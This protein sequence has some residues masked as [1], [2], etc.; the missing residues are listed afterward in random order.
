MPILFGINSSF[1]PNNNIP[2]YT[3]MENTKPTNAG[4]V[5]N[6]FLK[7]MNNEDFNAARK[8]AR[9]DMKFVGVLGSRDGA[10]AYFQDMEKMKFK[11]EIKRMFTDNDDVSV[12][13]DINMGDN[14]IFSSGWYHVI[15]GKINNIRVVFDP[16]P[17]LESH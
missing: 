17:L 7:A 1:K 2:C 15:D 5:V 13:Y 12:F 10:D 9:D 3:T 14:T 4:E 8:Y 6:A 11:Y 16:R